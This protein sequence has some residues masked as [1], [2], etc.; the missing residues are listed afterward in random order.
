MKHI[1]EYNLFEK[2][3]W[4]KS[5]KE[6]L[7]YVD[8]LKNN[9]WVFL[10]TETTGLLGPK[11]DQLTQISAIVIDPK[12]LETIDTFNQK[13]KL[14][15]DIKKILDDEVRPG[16]NR[17][18]VL[19]FNHYGDKIKGKKY[20]DE[21]EVLIMFED[22]LDTINNPLFI[23][24]NAEFDMNMLNGRK[25]ERF[26]RIEV[27]DTKDFIQLYII[28]IYQKLAETDITYKEKLEKIGTSTRDNGL[29]SSAM[30][31]W[32]TEFNIDSSGYHDALF[33]CEMM[34]KM[35]MTILDIM[36]ENIDLDITKYQKE[37]IK[38]V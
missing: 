20:L 32:A 17:R 26:K 9:M 22:W 15:D 31:K 38:T 4:N 25:K 28:P 8:K 6:M 37:R 33:D 36:K 11:N 12:T 7:N 16:W 35:F 2:K 14:T 30:S 13:I 34:F 10:D 23:I 5:I 27:L 21:Q 1:I 29:I 19:S 18:N 3:M 24:Q